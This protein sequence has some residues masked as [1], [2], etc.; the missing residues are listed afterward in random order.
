V[1]LDKDGPPD[2]PIRRVDSSA[3]RCAPAPG[4]W[5]GPGR[6]RAGRIV[7]LRKEHLSVDLM[8]M[9]QTC[10]LALLF[11]RQVLPVDLTDVVSIPL[12]SSTMQHAGN[13]DLR[14]Q[15]SV[16]DRDSKMIQFMSLTNTHDIEIANH[17]VIDCS[18]CFKM[19][20]GFK[21]LICADGF[22]QLGP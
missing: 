10:V 2:P 15:N 5:H 9:K 6:R 21:S 1:S 11:F 18:M 22:L 19:I 13:S 7:Q 14:I 4:P 3:P 17:W 12:K 16:E 8:G 20:T